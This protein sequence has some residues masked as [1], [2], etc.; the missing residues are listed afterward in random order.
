[1]CKPC[2]LI[3]TAAMLLAASAGVA[4]Q[5]EPLFGPMTPA[6]VS[7]TWI[8]QGTSSEGRVE[9]S[10]EFTMTRT[11]AVSSYAI[12]SDDVRLGGVATATSSMSGWYPPALVFV[13]DTDW[14]MEDAEG[15]WSGSSHFVASMADDDPI[16]ADERV[17]LDGSGAYEGLTAYLLIADADE[18]FVGVILPDEMPELPADWMDIYQAAAAEGGAADDRSGP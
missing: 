13:V 7:G 14:V 16:N 12:T 9:R 6:R 5:D 3:L 11:G 17:V 8:Y 10:G 4:A 1:M 18:T 15:S 2:F